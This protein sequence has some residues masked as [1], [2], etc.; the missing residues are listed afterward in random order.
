MR[1]HGSV[2]GESID[3]IHGLYGYSQQTMGSTFHSFIYTRANKIQITLAEVT[4]SIWTYMH[5]FFFPKW[6]SLRIWNEEENN[7]TLQYIFNIV[8]QI[9]LFED[10]QITQRK[11]K[12]KHSVFYH[13]CYHNC[14]T[15]TVCVIRFNVWNCGLTLGAGRKPQTGFGWILDPPLSMWEWFGWYSEASQSPRLVWDQNSNKWWQRCHQN[16]KPSKS[17]ILIYYSEVS[18]LFQWYTISNN[19][20]KYKRYRRMLTLTLKHTFKRLCVQ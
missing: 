9:L 3:V 6:L 16:H 1:M 7:M 12:S 18:K 8:C 13:N 17:Q 11:L 14:L 5:M 10:A 19:K 4:W 15:F 20:K 2:A